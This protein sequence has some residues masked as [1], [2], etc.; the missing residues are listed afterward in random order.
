MKT[1]ASISFLDNHSLSMDVEDV[2]LIEIT[3]P[4]EV[5]PGLW[6][7]SLLVRSETGTVALQLLTDDPDSLTV[8]EASEA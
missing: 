2:R 7:A 3:S 5:E 1:V 4:M 8:K 6:T